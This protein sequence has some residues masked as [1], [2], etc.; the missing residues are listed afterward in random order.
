MVKF[1]LAL[2]QDAQ[3]LKYLNDLFNGENCNSI[4]RIRESLDH[5]TQEIVCVAEDEGVLLGFC[6]GQVFK[7]MCYEVNY[8]E[9]TEL[10]ILDDYRR[11]GVGKGLM[12][13]LEG[14]FQKQDIRSYQLFTGRDN[15]IAKRFYQSCGYSE[16][17][18]VMFR[19][20]L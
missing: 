8:G 20:R 12:A 2:V 14:E 6:C 4:E 3:S 5:N 10:F 15:D 16:D 19:K 18:E 9:I 1:R 11:K 13:F 7:S 17:T